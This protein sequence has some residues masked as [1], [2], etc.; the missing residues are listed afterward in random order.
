MTAEAAVGP[1]ARPPARLGGHDD[2]PV[3]VTAD[4][5]VAK[6][7]P[8]AEL[9][10]A[11]ARTLAV[12]WASP[13]G[14]GRTPPGVP[15]PEPLAAGSRTVLMERLVGSPMSTLAGRPA[16]DLVAEVARLLADLHR[17]GVEVGRRRSARGVVRALGRKAADLPV[18]ALATAY[19]EIVARAAAATPADAELVA[20]HGDF[21][22]ANVL[23]TA[24]GPRL[25]D[26]DRAQLAAPTRDLAYWG[27][28]HW[29]RAL[30]A[31]DEP[32]WAAGGALAAAY[33]ALRPECA[34]A[35]SGTVDFHRAAAL[36]RAVHG[37]SAFASR[38]DAAARVVAEAGR[39]LG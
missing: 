12:L 28:W 35:V 17:S 11:A 7:Y 39:Q 2:R 9:A 26:L 3:F 29:V 36:L 19:G 23:V 18:G 14:A 30:L 21:S 13:F 27:A 10:T 8:T 5:L 16:A 24:A 20:C 25:I 15:C 6:R 22:P 1:V 37:W 4:G 38:P 34:A 32:S 31:G 33:V